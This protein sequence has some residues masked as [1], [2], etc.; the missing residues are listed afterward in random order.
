[1]FNIVETIKPSNAKTADRIKEKKARM[2]S[3]NPPSSTHTLFHSPSL[4]LLPSFFHSR[5]FHSHSL[6][7][8][9]HSYAQERST[10]NTN[11]LSLAFVCP[12]TPSAW[13]RTHICRNGQSVFL[14]ALYYWNQRRVLLMFFYTMVETPVPPVMVL[15]AGVW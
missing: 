2:A 15:E 3:L 9:S 6:L 14:T 4:S 13:H 12:L 8:H 7:A 5:H 10:P 1:M 11:I